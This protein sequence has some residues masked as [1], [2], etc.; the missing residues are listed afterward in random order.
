VS[1]DQPT[2][3]ELG[4]LIG[5]YEEAHK[6][7]DGSLAKIDD[8][9]DKG[10]KKMSELDLKIERGFAEQ[11]LETQKLHT[12]VEKVNG[13]LQNHEKR[14][15]LFHVTEEETRWGRVKRHK[16]EIGIPT[17]VAGVVALIIGALEYF[18]VI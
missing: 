17:G 16:Y 11:K 6:H 1:S 8:S 9:L 18:G 7:L 12:N 13:A 5:K 15:H 4:Q 2:A 10:T 14:P 3:Y